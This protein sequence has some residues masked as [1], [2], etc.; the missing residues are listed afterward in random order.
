MENNINSEYL[1]SVYNEDGSETKCDAIAVLNDEDLGNI[2][3]YTDYTKNE[4]NKYNVYASKL[5]IEEDN[6]TKLEELNEEEIN[7]PKIQEA[8]FIALERIQEKLEEQ[9][10]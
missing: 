1:F 8:I 7:L 6:S 4:E 9:E 2:I 3:I 10:N 5:T